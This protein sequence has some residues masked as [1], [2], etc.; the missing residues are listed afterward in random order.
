[1]GAYLLSIQMG[2]MGVSMTRRLFC[3]VRKHSLSHSPLM[4]S[5]SSHLNVHGCLAGR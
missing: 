5:P 4:S 3:H 2:W 1:M